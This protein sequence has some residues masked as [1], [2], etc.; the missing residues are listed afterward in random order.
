MSPFLPDAQRFLIN[1]DDLRDEKL[2][3]PR[4]RLES[5]DFGIDA[6]FEETIDEGT[7]SHDF[8]KLPNGEPMK[9]QLLPSG[10]WSESRDAHDGGAWE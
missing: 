6:F 7:L 4:K 5:A 9:A 10:L 2:A 1:P 3:N 8:V